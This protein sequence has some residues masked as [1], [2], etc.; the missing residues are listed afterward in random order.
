MNLGHIKA[1]MTV[2][3]IYKEGLGVNYD[4]QK[5]LESFQKLMELDAGEGKHQVGLLYYHGFV[6]IEQDFGAAYFHFKQGH[7]LG[8]PHCT[9]HL[10]WMTI[11]GQGVP[12]SDLNAGMK[13]LKTVEDKSDEAQIYLGFCALEG[14]GQRCDAKQAFTYFQKATNAGH[15]EGMLHLAFMYL[16]G[17]GVVQSSWDASKLLTQAAEKG[18]PIA[19]VHL[20]LQKHRRKGIPLE[21]MA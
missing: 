9:A 20:G 6:L 8:N 16:H 17:R 13:L 5:V 19:Q 1:T 3:R 7:D 4:S 18:Q 11:Q 14:I 2:G 15:A 10:G 21:N 12:S